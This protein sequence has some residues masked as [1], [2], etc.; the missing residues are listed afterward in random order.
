MVELLLAADDD[1]GSGL[2]I[3]MIV[4]TILSFVAY[5]APTIIAVVRKVPNK[6]SV[7]VINL[8]LGWTVIGWIIA[9]AMAARSRPEPQQYP[10]PPQ[11][12]YPDQRS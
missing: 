11:Y 9:L 12:Q 5:W 7:I 6:G 8:F 2:G 3:G 10:Y 1:T 4:L